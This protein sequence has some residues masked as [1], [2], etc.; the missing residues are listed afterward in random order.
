MKKGGR[1]SKMMF[2]FFEDWISYPVS[3]LSSLAI[4]KGWEVDLTCFAEHLSE[5]QIIERLEQADLDLLALSFMTCNRRLAFDVARL[6]KERGIKT[7][8]GGVHPSACPEDVARSGFFDGIVTG[9]GMG[10]F[11]GILDRYLQLHGQIIPGAR[12]QDISTYY[13]RYYSESQKSRMI[14]SKQFETMSALGCPMSCAYCAAKNRPFIKLPIKPIAQQI[15]N[16]Y[17]DF[18]TQDILF[19]DDIFTL[20]L[21]R[22]KTF[23]RIVQEN[24]LDCEYRLQGRVDRLGD[25]IAAELKALGVEDVSVGVE[26]VSEKLLKFLNKRATVEQTYEMAETM[27]RYG[28]ALGIHLLF[29]LPTQDQEDY[30]NTLTFIHQVKPYRIIPHFFVPLPGSDLFQYCFDHGYM[31]EDFSF[32]DCY[33]QANQLDIKGSKGQPGILKKV[34]YEMALDYFHKFMDIHN[35]HTDKVIYDAAETA[36]KDHWIVLGAGDYYYRV[37][38]RLSRRKWKNLLGCYD[39]TSTENLGYRTRVFPHSISEYQWLGNEQQPK[40]IVVTKHYGRVFRRVIEPL[41]RKEKGF[42]GPILSAGTLGRNL[43]TE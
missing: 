10:V 11:G 14:Y 33:I 31:P 5:S 4:K 6:A 12:H 36:D 23:R 29:G 3:I 8:A 7:I 20:S 41:L 26:T 9:D 1:M 38:D 43:T 39:Y 40:S 42:R 19:Q 21:D 25:G 18:G 2:G 13:D 22:V 16:A 24:G 27:N 37:L 35:Q 30:E 17:R 28:L 15:V 34:D 32:D